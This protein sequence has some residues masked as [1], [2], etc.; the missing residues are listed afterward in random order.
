MDTHYRNA[1]GRLK[2]LDMAKDQ[3][4]R[5]YMLA[6]YNYMA[7][8]LAVTG[9]VAF[10]AAHSPSLMYTLFMTP[11]KWV[12]FFAPL[13]VVL[14]LQVRIYTMSS[15]AAQVT[16][17]VY[18]GLMGL[19]MASIFALYTGQSIARV[20]FITSATFG[21]M[22]LYG[23]TTRRDL[24]GFGS[25]LFMGLLGIVVASV[26]NIFLHSSA[27]H[28]AVSFLGVF[29][30]TGLTAYDTQKIKE[31]YYE[32]DEESVISRKAILGALNLY[33]D[34]INLFLTLLR[35]LGDRR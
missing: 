12:V 4:L 22:S 19:S 21:G 26:V 1:A 31:M 17:W 13:G 29:I 6:V 15:A 28:Y 20:F 35:F 5:S 18:A 8:A 24:S 16:F 14:F 27:L 25:F 7:L 23:Y 2:T 3:G 10:L 11:L 32:A 34:F 33:L 9:G 30:F